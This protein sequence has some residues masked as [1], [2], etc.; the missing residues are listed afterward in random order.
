MMRPF[1]IIALCLLSGCSPTKTNT[2]VLTAPIAEPV[3]T[4]NIQAEQ[5]GTSKKF[6]LYSD[7]EVEKLIKEK[8][9]KETFEGF[10][11]FRVNAYQSVPRS[12]VFKDLGIDEKRIHCRGWSLIQYAL[13]FDWQMSPSYDISCQTS[14]LSEISGNKDSDFDMKNGNPPSPAFRISEVRIWKR[15]K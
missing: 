15:S 8:D 4:P 9:I 7:E 10:I 11:L 12:E 2:E 14:V 1:S 6:P 13:I 3:A 5:L